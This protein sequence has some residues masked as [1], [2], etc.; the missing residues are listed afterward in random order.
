MSVIL[1]QFLA[2]FKL[3]YVLMG[4]HQSLFKITSNGSDTVDLNLLEQ[5]KRIYDSWEW[6]NLEEIY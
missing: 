6:S 2:I 5:G 1:I 3:E 4:S